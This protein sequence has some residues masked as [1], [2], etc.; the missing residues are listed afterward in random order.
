MSN[1]LKI[2]KH[3]ITDLEQFFG[4]RYKIFCKNIIATKLLVTVRFSP[5]KIFCNATI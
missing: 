3:C 1:D 5:P 4:I 2:A